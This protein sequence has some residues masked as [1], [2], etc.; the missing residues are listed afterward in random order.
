MN[1]RTEKAVFGA[2]CFWCT[3]AVYQ[4]IKGV[5]DIE[6]GYAGGRTENPTYREVIYNN[7]GHIEV[8]KITYDPEI[9]NYKTLVDIFWTMHDPTSLDKQGADVGQ[10]YRSAIFYQNEE[11]RELANQSRRE[12]QDTYDQPIVTE[13]RK[14]EKFYPA[15]NHHHKYYSNNPD[16][17]YCRV[18]ISPKVNKLRNQFTDLLI[19]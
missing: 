6:V 17:G 14:L 9:I 16:A 15:E 4:E 5:V 2:G 7:T 8:A 12:A 13:I 18:V 1:K 19:N 11:Q 3:E 10:Q